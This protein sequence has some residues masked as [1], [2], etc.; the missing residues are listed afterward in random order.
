MDLT[1][2]PEQQLIFLNLHWGRMYIFTAPAQGTATWTARARFG[3][4]DELHADSATELLL[5][6]RSHYAAKKFP[7]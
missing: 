1:G 4:Q 5:A 2:T 3:D 7:G 6:V